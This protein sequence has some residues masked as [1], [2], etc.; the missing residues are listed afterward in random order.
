MCL[1]PDDEVID[2]LAPV[3][4]AEVGHYPDAGLKLPDFLVSAIIREDHIAGDG[5]KIRIRVA[6]REKVRRGAAH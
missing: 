5:A 1:A 3:G 4:D 2:R 6:D